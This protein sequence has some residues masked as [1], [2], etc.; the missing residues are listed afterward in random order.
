MRAKIDINF[1]EFARHLYE[2][3]VKQGKYWSPDIVIR[4]TWFYAPFSQHFNIG[5]TEVDIY[6]T[7]WKN[8]RNTYFKRFDVVSKEM[9]IFILER[10]LREHF[11]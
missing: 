11:G 7:K 9:E 3:N 5:C 1:P 10:T 2:H 6:R 8:T 4:H